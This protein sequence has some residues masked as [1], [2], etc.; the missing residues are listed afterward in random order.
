MTEYFIEN[1]IA[2]AISALQDDTIGINSKITAINTEKADFEIELI[3]DRNI[4]YGLKFEKG[5][6]EFP[7]IEVK[8]ERT[9]FVIDAERTA[10]QEHYI[11]FNFWLSNK[12]GDLDKLQKA[13][14]RYARAIDEVL[15]D[16]AWAL[17]VLECWIESHDYDVPVETKD[18]GFIGSGAVN[19]TFK[20][21]E[22]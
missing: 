14:Y 7:L 10:E 2:Q 16:K 20:T 8:G 17:P 9:S 13:Q 6:A 11:I 4:V 19:T 21:E 5:A 18:E 22:A 3:L 15:R 12:W 1:I